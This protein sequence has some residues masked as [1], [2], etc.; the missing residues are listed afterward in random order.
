MPGQSPDLGRHHTDG[1]IPPRGRV[2]VADDD[3]LLREGVA[4]LLTREGFEIIGQ[5]GDGE[6]LL[7]LVT[8][9]VPDIAIVDVRLPPPPK[10]GEPPPGPFGSRP[11]L[12]VSDTDAI[13]R[14]GVSSSSSY[15]PGR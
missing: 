10:P 4:S 6:E 5:A 12:E 7:G 8:E 11:P 15:I 14:H 2:I 3:V 13:Y 1:P 9:L